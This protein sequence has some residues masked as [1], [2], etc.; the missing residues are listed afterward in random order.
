MGFVVTAAAFE[1]DDLGDDADP[2]TLRRWF[3]KLS[4]LK[5]VP[6]YLV[7]SPPPHGDM[8]LSS[9]GSSPE[10]SSICSCEYR[11]YSGR[12]VRQFPKKYHY[13]KLERTCRYSTCKV[14]QKCD[15]TNY[16]DWDNNRSCPYCFPLLLLL[17]SFPTPILIHW[18]VATTTDGKD[19]DC[20]ALR[21]TAQNAEYTSQLTGIEELLNAMPHDDAILALYED[22]VVLMELAKHCMV[23][24]THLRQR[25]LCHL[26]L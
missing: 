23:T 1:N 16:L 11:L 2:T 17:L 12:E 9:V 8:W 22:L 10:I 4:G 13:S 19:G 25:C 3:W 5:L 18:T 20:K 15:P 26:G 6:G 14:L 21:L 24:E 7:K